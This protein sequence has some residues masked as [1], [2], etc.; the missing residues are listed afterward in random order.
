MV[1]GHVEKINSEEGLSRSLKRKI[2]ELQKQYEKQGL[3]VGGKKLK[4]KG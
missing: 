2:E 4:S 1:R 3:K